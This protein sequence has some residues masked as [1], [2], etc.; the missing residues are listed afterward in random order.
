M[1]QVHWILPNGDRI[2]D[3]ILEGSNLMDA[4]QLNGV[5]GVE[6]ECGGCLSCA[7]CHVLVDE[8]WQ[9]VCPP[10]TDIEHTMLDITTTPRQPGSRLSCQLIASAALDGIVLH[11]PTDSGN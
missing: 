3:D 1:P 6:G 10:M 5:P 11:V 9:K 7:T 8:A 4:A 2:S